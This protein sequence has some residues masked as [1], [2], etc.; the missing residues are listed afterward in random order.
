MSISDKLKILRNILGRTYQSGDESLFYCPKC[1]HHKAKLSVNVEKNAFKCWVCDYS[2]SSIYRL[3]RRYGN[4]DQKRQ[5][6]K[7]DGV[8]DL[9][10]FERLA[11]SLFEKQEEE[12]QE[13]VS[14]PSEFVSL[15]NKSS[16]HFDTQ[17]RNYLNSRGITQE[18]IV[19]WKI[20]YCPEGA[21]KNRIIVPSFGASGMP[22]YFVARTYSDD[23]KTY[24]NPNVSKNNMIFNHLY[25]D[26]DD[27]LVITEGIFD[28]IVAGKNSVPL[29]GSTLREGS[30]L[31]QEIVSN[32]TPVY[33]AMDSDAEKK[34][35]MLINR[36]LSYGVEVH[37]IDIHPFSDVA[38]MTRDE[39]LKR[40]EES[41]ILNL[42]NY[43]FY[44]IKNSLETNNGNYKRATKTDY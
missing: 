28:A 32:V 19:Y 6:K 16:S 23:W 9:D 12:I 17:P 21:Y 7:L 26:F 41:T 14:L 37:K 11:H 4:Y 34:A 15:A 31:F 13:T 27:D 44:K 38:E 29:L 42:E 18:D 36:L 39:F 3:V 10:R 25:L 20:G 1:D 22:N 5:W 30:K 40:K 8:V 35:L 2:G 43:L 24:M 33:M